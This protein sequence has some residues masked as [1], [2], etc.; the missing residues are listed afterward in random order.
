MRKTKR[1]LFIFALITVIVVTLFAFACSHTGEGAER[2]LDLAAEDTLS[3]S[4]ATSVTSGNAEQPS[5][6]KTTADPTEE[7]SDTP[8]SVTEEPETPTSGDQT[9]TDG[10]ERTT[11]DTQSQ[12]TTNGNESVDESE[13]RDGYYRLQE[14]DLGDGWQVFVGDREIGSALFHEDAMLSIP[15]LSES[16]FEIWGRLDEYEHIEF[17]LYFPLFEGFRTMR[18]R[19]ELSTVQ[20]DLTA[21][22]LERL[23][24]TS[25]L[26]EEDD[27]PTDPPEETGDDTGEDE[28]EGQGSGDEVIPAE[29]RCTSC[30]ALLRETGAHLSSCSHY[31]VLP[32]ESAITDFL[33]PL[34]GMKE[35][36]V[37]TALDG[38]NEIWSFVLNYLSAE[39]AERIKDAMLTCDVR[40]NTLLPNGARDLQV[41]KASGG[42]MFTVT[43]HI[44]WVGDGYRAS[45]N[46]TGFALE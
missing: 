34:P 40:G 39:G 5:N 1:F 29:A 25:S 31:A 26:D 28:G 19:D 45:I 33:S 16:P 8:P 17:A 43:A 36:L 10:A 46:L 6:E 41:R 21:E 14:C 12:S 9:A 18:L 44:E 11:E 38:E 4:A 2:S 32:I 22:E 20:I 27:P 30:G 3:S 15:A 7:S 24:P 35:D 23:V 37:L 42:K 13:M